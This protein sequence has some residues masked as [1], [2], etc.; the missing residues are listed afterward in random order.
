MTAA[1]PA[2]RPS[3]LLPLREEIGL[4]PG[5]A[6]FDG[7]PTWTLHDPSCNRFFRLGW[8]EFELI[9]RWEAGTV[10][11]L[12]ERVRA[13]TT[14]EVDK[15]DVEQLARFLFGSN[16]LRAT[17]PDATAELV[18][19]AKRQQRGFWHW[20][21]H[22]YLFMRIPLFR[23]DAF[24]TAT[25]PYARVVFSRVLALA[26]LALGLIGIYMVARQWD[27]FLGTFVD[28]FT[29]EGIVG[30]ALTLACLKVV[31]EFGHAYTAKRYGCRVPTMGLALLVLFPV[32]YSDINEA[33]KLRSRQQRLAIG[34]AGVT[35][36]LACAAV[37][38][39]AWAML[40]SGPAR[41]IAFLVATSTWLTT[42][43]I[44]FSPFMRYD[45]YYVLS[46]WLEIPNLHQRAFALAQWWLRETLLGLGDP[47]PEEQPLHRQ[48]LLV[49][50]AFLTWLYRFALFLAIAVIVYHFAIK[51][52]GVVMMVVE[53]G[54]FI[55]WPIVSEMK[56]WWDRR[57][58]IRL[59]PRTALTGTAA[60]AIVLLL[61]IPW[62]SSVEAPALL[63]SQQHVR[64]FA[65]DFGARVAEVKVKDG[66]RVEKGE[67]LM[68]LVSP[69]IDYRLGRARIEL[70]IL[71]WQMGARGATPEFLARSLVTE[72]EYDTALAEYRSLLDQKSR[73]DVTAPIP[74]KVVDVAPALTPGTWLPAKTRLLSVVDPAA[75]TVEA[76]VDEGDLA[77]IAV[78]ESATFF[79][80]ADSRIE[81]PLRVTEI[82][83][84]STR[85]LT[86][87]YL[88]STAGG[89]ITVRAPKQNE[90][91]PDRTI[92]RV[93]LA[94]AQDDAKGIDRVL[95]GWV[96]MRGE[97]KSVLARAWRALLVVLIRESGA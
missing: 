97:A 12:T 5:P 65:P 16:L 34:L 84:A 66:D 38:L 20:V 29:V 62:R 32:L 80:E 57:A 50:F 52:L 72:R 55:A 41:S 69:D 78:G 89:P 76:Y 23:S 64:V 92:Y 44:N 71:E 48:R 24:L 45:G 74:G 10:E 14:V 17:S 95:R 42:V 61:V 6:A 19:R 31:H 93:T 83:R 37:A 81:V 73:L 96:I 3:T 91:I 49:V 58:D 21:L 87:P 63:K 54:Y 27:V 43:M 94:L 8:Q 75:I 51:I 15:G 7:S 56:T 88:A 13:E 39:F 1:A 22:N 47:V 79:S 53:V 30:F 18:K 70:E 85:L 67:R 35:A 11:A 82:A 4:F 86:E 26:I 60:A 46:D 2:A 33:W 77:R 68:G 90:L 59:T 9:S 36:E 40:P 28:F 25:Y